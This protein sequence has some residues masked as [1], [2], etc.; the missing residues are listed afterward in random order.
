M[1]GVRLAPPTVLFKL[2]ALG[3][4]LLVLRRVVVTT[5]ALLARECHQCPHNITSLKAFR[6]R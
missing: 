1:D 6:K 3:V 2:D 4:V 5:F